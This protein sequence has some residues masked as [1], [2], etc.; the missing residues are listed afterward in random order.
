M[1]VWTLE[2][3][4]AR[5]EKWKSSSLILS[6]LDNEGEGSLFQCLKALNYVR[7]IETDSP[8]GIDTPFWMISIEFDLTET[9]IANYQKVLALIFEYIRTVKDLWLQKGKG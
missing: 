3:D 5:Q 2:A 4:T 7:D 8:E 6:L 1:I 9:G